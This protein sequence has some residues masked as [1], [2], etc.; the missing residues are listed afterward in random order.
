M[1]D[2]DKEKITNSHKSKAVRDVDCQVLHRQLH[3]PGEP[4][5]FKMWMTGNAQG[6][7]SDCELE[8]GEEDAS[9]AGNCAACTATV[10]NGS[11]W[12]LGLA[13][14]PICTQKQGHKFPCCKCK[15]CL[16]SRIQMARKIPLRAGQTAPCRHNSCLFLALLAPCRS[17]APSGANDA[18]WISCPLYIL[19]YT[20]Q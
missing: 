11:L 17:T 2:N 8:D 7:E 12:P 14:S 6:V 1:T 19:Y 15:S 16:V 4:K 10:T 18:S 9:S 13:G 20:S 5:S 3:Q